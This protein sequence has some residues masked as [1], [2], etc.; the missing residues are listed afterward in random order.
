MAPEL[1]RTCEKVEYGSEVDVY[2]LGVLLWSVIMRKEPYGD[3]IWDINEFMEL[4]LC[5]KLPRPCVT[6]IANKDLAD[7]I[8]NMWSEDP[9]ARSPISVCLT[10]LEKL[11]N[12]L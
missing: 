12:S 3:Q 5:K 6:S 10:K 9:Q 2:S 4:I 7:L 8:E 11:S 1:F